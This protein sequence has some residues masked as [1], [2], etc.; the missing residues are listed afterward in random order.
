M[1]VPKVSD[2][3]IVKVPTGSRVL[4]CVSE[5]LSRKQLMKLKRVCESA[6]VNA[7]GVLVVDVRAM[8]LS[9]IDENGR[10]VRVLTNVR[11]ST[12]PLPGVLNLSTSVVSLAP[13]ERVLATLYNESPRSYQRATDELVRWVGDAEAVVVMQ[14]RPA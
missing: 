10:Q 3:C 7:V 13:G 2:M 5:D 11:G 4:A 14:T 12:R 6:F 8:Q 9:V 1:I